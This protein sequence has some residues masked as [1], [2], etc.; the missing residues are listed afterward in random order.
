MFCGSDWRRERALPLYGND[1]RLSPRWRTRL[2]PL[3]DA[4]LSPRWRIGPNEYQR[5]NAIQF[6][7]PD[8][9]PLH[10][11]PNTPLPTVSSFPCP[12]FLSSPCFLVPSPLVPSFPL[13]PRSLTPRS[14]VPLVSND[15][16]ELVQLGRKNDLNSTVFRL[17]LRVN[18]VVFGTPGS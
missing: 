15:V 5:S 6:V 2:S 7:A 10:E 18:R 11:N 1:T 13:F 16:V 17:V 8:R 4:R 3:E 9:R 14:L 12:S